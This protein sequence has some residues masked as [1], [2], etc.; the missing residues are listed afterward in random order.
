M[1]KREKPPLLFWGGI[2]IAALVLVWWYNEVTSWLGGRAGDT[3]IHCLLVF[4]LGSCSKL[5]WV[6]LHQANQVASVAFYC[7]VAVAIRA[8]YKST[9]F[10]WVDKR[11]DALRHGRKWPGQ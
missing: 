1:T 5:W 10:T 7:A 11:I 3:A 4:G 6:G 2:I 9:D 8:W